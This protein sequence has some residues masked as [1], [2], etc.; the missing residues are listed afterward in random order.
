[1]YTQLNGSTDPVTGT[2]TAPSTITPELARGHLL[3]NGNSSTYLLTAGN[4]DNH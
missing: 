1:M 2:V 3:A 4:V